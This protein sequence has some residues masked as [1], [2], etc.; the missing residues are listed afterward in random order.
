MPKKERIP[1]SLSQVDI[2]IV[3]QI[4]ENNLGLHLLIIYNN[5]RVKRDL[6][7]QKKALNQIKYC[8]FRKKYKR[9]I[10]KISKFL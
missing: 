10:T 7:N 4:Q 1:L 6:F 3:Q 2:V 9:I 5:K 8:K